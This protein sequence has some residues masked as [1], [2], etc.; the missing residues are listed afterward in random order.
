[1]EYGGEA[2]RSEKGM[3]PGTNE[4]LGSTL[5]SVENFKI[6]ID[7]GTELGTLVGSL[8]G[9]NVGIPKGALLGDQIE[10]ARCGA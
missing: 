7:Y 1:M 4:V 9:S 3:V 10:D 5:G 2:L 6:G 8:E